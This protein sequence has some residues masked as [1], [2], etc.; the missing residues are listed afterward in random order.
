MT[1]NNQRRAAIDIA[2]SAR[3]EPAVGRS[4][5]TTLRLRQNPGR[6][7]YTVLSRADGSLTPGGI[8]YYAATGLATPSS[9]FDRG[10]PLVKKGAGDYVQTRNGKLALVRKLL[11]DGTTHVTRLGKQYFKN[12]KT[13]YVVSVPV[14]ISGTNARGRVQ[15]R[16]TLLPVDMLGIGRILQDNSVSVS[17]ASRVARVKSH[18]L[19]KLTISTMGGES[20]LMQVSNETFTYNREGQWLIS[21]LTTSVQDGVAST[22]AV[23]RQPLGS[24]LSCAAFLAHADHVVDSAFESHDDKLCV[25]RQLA[26]VL[27]VSIDTAIG[28]FD[29]FLE[30]GWQQRGVSALEVRML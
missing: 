7:S 23:M 14:R 5:Q 27:G 10:T 30:P 8:H 2:I 13:E 16:T 17:E 29:E 6:S 1:L 20:V 18:V 28:Y 11:P 12:P 26:D 15:N 3:T 4:G 19:E 24:L 22:Q 9:Q 25:P 21:Q